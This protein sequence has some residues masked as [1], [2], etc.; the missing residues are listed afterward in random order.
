[1]KTPVPSNLL[2]WDP[3]LLGEPLGADAQGLDGAVPVLQH[4][5]QQVITG[6]GL[7]FLDLRGR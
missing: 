1:M 3:S 4:H 7:K 5:F 6:A 2:S